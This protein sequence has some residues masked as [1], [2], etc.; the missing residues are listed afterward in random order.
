[1][2]KKNKSKKNQDEKPVVDKAIEDKAIKKLEKKE[3]KEEK[4][5]EK[6][7]KKE[8]GEKKEKT[9][10]KR[11]KLLSIDVYD[12]YGTT[13]SI[14][15]RGR[16]VQARNTTEA[17]KLDSKLKNFKRNAELLRP[18]TK[19]G[20]WVKVDLNGH[21]LEDLTKKDGIFN[22]EFTDIDLVPGIQEAEVSLSIK[23]PK[24]LI[25]EVVRGQLVVHPPESTN[26]SIVSDLDDTIQVTDV[27]RRLKFINNIFL[28]NYK[29]QQLIVPGLN[30]LFRA[31]QHG[32]LGDGYEATH[33]VSSSPIHLF[34]RIDSFLEFNEFP[35]GSIDLKQPALFD[36]EADSWFKHRTYK[37]D[38]IR[39]IVQTFPKRRFVLFGDNG[40][41]DPEIYHQIYEDFSEQ[42]IGIYINNVHPDEVTELEFEEQVLMNHV[43]DAA[44]DLLAKGIITKVDYKVIKEQEEKEEQALEAEENE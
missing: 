4:K 28:K 17:S 14:R 3:K 19:E 16:I 13:D 24:N 30:K 25:A 12:G 27:K 10:S 11:L 2:L 32:P 21:I 6:R 9:P 43:L 39:K 40:E 7:E 31:I 15:V 23:N 26:V 33:Y 44:D 35:E 1:M 38:K 42:I 34:K 5:K 36:K 37:L 8:K 22:V 20:I 41:R 29:T 18:K